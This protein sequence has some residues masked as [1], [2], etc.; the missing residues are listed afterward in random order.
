MENLYKKPN[1]IKELEDKLKQAFE[2]FNIE[3]INDEPVEFKPK[4]DYRR[5]S[6]DETGEIVGL[7]ISGFQ[8]GYQ[9]NEISFLKELKHL[10]LLDLSGNRN[11]R[12]IEALSELVELKKLDLRLNLINNLEPLA[13]LKKLTHLYLSSND[14]KSIEALRNLENLVELGIAGGTTYNRVSDISSI[15]NLIKLKYLDIQY[16][17]ISNISVLENFPKLKRLNCFMNKISDISALQNLKELQYLNLGEN[18]IDDI[19]FLQ[20][21][22]KLEKLELAGT[23]ISNITAL[24]ELVGLTFL[25]LS[26]NYDIEDYTPIAG[27]LKNK[28]FRALSIRGIAYIPKELLNNDREFVNDNSEDGLQI[29]GVDYFPPIEMVRLGYNK[30]K[31]YYDNYP[32]KLL[33]EYIR[34]NYKRTGIEEVDE[35]E[36]YRVKKETEKKIVEYL[37]EKKYEKYNNNTLPYSVR[38]IKIENYLGIQNLYIDTFSI[39]EERKE[40][41]EPNW[42]FFTG[43]NGF[44][45][46]SI[47]RAILRGLS[48]GGKEQLK[49]GPTDRIT[50]EYCNND[51]I[52]VRENSFHTSLKKEFDRTLS[53]I[54]AYGASRIKLNPEADEIPVSDSLF[55]ETDYIL[56]FESRFKEME[57]IPELKGN[58]EKI[59]E[60]L[61]ELI[62]NLDKIEIKQKESGLG[63]KVV[64][65]EKDVY[66]NQL[67]PVEFEQ[68]ATGMRSIIGL[69]T[70]FIFRLAKNQEINDNLSGI[71]I[72]DEFDNHL[73]PKWQKMLVEKLTKLFPKI[74]FIVST[75]SPIPLLGAPANS[76]IL[77]VNRTKEEGITVEKLDIDFTTLTPNAILTSPIFD[78]Q[79]IIPTYKSKDKFL[80]TK[81]DFQEIEKDEKRRKKISEFLTKEKTE[82]FL[83]LLEKE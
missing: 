60:I 15:N 1:I 26:N 12:D 55:G 47:L 81:S 31:F 62:P 29:N 19:S 27:L 4:T 79:E 8:S 50:I 39:N 69:V 41:N 5:Y 43:N 11:I 38:K 63:T 21:L 53:E 6:V 2:L 73:H 40:I 32:E 36:E 34:P 35:A 23:K 54:A 71:V 28:N 10:I 76:I 83:K 64:Y 67:T 52:L 17:Q 18:K 13:N 74:Q 66:G 14:F 61:K 16:Q 33:N 49:G 42:I 3:N 22:N 80:R 77:N 30:Y 46:T 72:I 51:K 70:D 65:Y 75:H 9:L 59:I 68:L 45:K 20:K 37:L 78:F 44:G 56:N 25:D 48:G 82:E 24:K 58:R 7:N 57:G